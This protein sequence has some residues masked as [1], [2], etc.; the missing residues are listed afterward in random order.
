MKVQISNTKGDKEGTIDSLIY[1]LEMAK[2]KG[3]TH[4]NMWWSGDPVWDFKWFELYR[5]KSEEEVKKDRIEVLE[6][7][8]KKLKS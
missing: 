8:L 4:F 5:I 3:A 2:M 1:D 7:E 6:S